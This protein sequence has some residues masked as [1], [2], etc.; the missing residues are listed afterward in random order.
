MKR[1]FVLAL[2]MLLI[3]IAANS[4]FAL[5]FPVD[6]LGYLD[7]S[8]PEGVSIVPGRSLDEYVIS[9]EKLPDI[10]SNAISP[11]SFSI[12]LRAIGSS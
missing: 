6:P 9:W 1:N 12:P 11:A 5:D 2:S 8:L 4:A 7:Y 10:S 3:M